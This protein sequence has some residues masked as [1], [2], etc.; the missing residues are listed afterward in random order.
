M[1]FFHVNG[2]LAFTSHSTDKEGYLKSLCVNGKNILTK[3][4]IEFSDG[5]RFFIQNQ[6]SHAPHEI[7]STT[8][9]KNRTRSTLLVHLSKSTLRIEVDETFSPK[10]IIR[11]YTI[12][13]LQDTHFMDISISQAFER[14]A[15]E[16]VEMNGLVLPFDGIERNHQF[17]VNHARL[18]G[19]EFDVE[20]D[21]DIPH[22]RTG[23]IPTIY[24]RSGNRFGWAIHSRLFPKSIAKKAIMWC[25][26]AWNKR[27]PFSDVLS[28][29]DPLVNYL[30]YVGEKPELAKRRT[31]G[32]AS[33]GL[34]LAPKNTP[35][36]MV[37]TLTLKPKKVSKK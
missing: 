20:I 18:V 15:F 2:M 28:K 12:F 32:F 9:E 8:I 7:I 35:I 5:D 31:F 25:N 30:W 11:R 22:N 36:E 16:H 6:Q 37:Q 24:S 4:G 3:W 10:K 29:I 14:N 23:L 21:F 34:A 1:E 19:K 27:V 26:A 33:F 17:E 13:P